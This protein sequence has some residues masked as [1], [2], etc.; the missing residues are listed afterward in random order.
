MKVLTSVGSQARV[1]GALAVVLDETS[2][3]SRRHL[4]SDARTTAM[5]LRAYVALDPQNPLVPKLVRGLLSL[6]R[7]GRFSTTQAC[8]WAL[9][10]LNEA[11]A[12][13]APRS[14]STTAHVF[15]DGKELTTVAIGGG[16]RE[17][18]SD[19]IP[20]ARLS[21]AG[22]ASLSFTTD[23]GRPSFTRARFATRARSHRRRRSTKA[24]MSRAMRVLR[25]DAPPVATTDLRVGDYVEVDVVLASP[26]PRDLVVLDDPCPRAS[27]P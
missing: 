12:V 14:A 6:R 11:R 26:V 25:A 5:V 23:D 20:M 16:G 10:A 24:C 15:F 19:S 17:A 9:L 3:S 4:S 18:W 7:D 21:T 13:F 27:R 22:S 2:L 8:A 1:T